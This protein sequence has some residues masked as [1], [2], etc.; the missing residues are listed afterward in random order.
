MGQLRFLNL[1]A[2]TPLRPPDLISTRYLLEGADSIASSQ[3]RPLGEMT[4]TM[5]DYTAM[6]L[7]AVSGFST[8]DTNLMA[9]D[10]G[11]I[12]PFLPFFLSIFF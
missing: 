2:R 12:S 9:S 10:D 7:N 3:L 8:H 4:W 5:I 6:K 11:L 1:T